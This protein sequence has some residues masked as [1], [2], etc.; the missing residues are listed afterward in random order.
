MVVVVA[1]NTDAST[2]K[3]V[4]PCNISAQSKKYSSWQEHYRETALSEVHYS[5]G[6]LYDDTFLEVFCCYT[7][8]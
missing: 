1:A 2:K 5:G 3:I 6:C 8:L 4:Q 7:D